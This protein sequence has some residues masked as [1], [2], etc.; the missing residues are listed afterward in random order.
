MFGVRVKQR[1]AE[2]AAV[3][4]FFGLLSGCALQRAQI[5]QQAQTALIGMSKADLLSCAG[6]PTRYAKAGDME[7]MTYV[8]G[9]DTHG[10]IGGGWGNSAGAADI[11]LY[12]RSCTANFTLRNDRVIKIT[13]AGRTGGLIT[14][15]EQC[16]FIIQNCVP[17]RPM[18]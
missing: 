17:G 12:Q 2:I 7:V 9:G 13:Y 16:A 4:A 3:A 15:G 8:G 14:Q 1:Y 18:L 10:T 11:S 5:A 6:A